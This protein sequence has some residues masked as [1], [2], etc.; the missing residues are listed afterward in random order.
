LYVTFG[1]GSPPAA[2]ASQLSFR[3]RQTP[4]LGGDAADSYTG[5][6]KTVAIIGAS[7]SRRKFGNKALRAFREAGYRAVPITPKHTTVEGEPAYATVL[8]Y[9]GQFD[10]ASVY[11]PPEV[12]E[13]LLDGLAAKGIVDVWFNPGSESDALIERARALGL[14]P[15][16]ACSIIG[17]GMSPGAF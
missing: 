15:I 7:S 4:S 10:F 12:G 9:P 13:T 11:V 8:D 14:R 16:E 6:M 17:I 2:G 3:V 1:R 5:A